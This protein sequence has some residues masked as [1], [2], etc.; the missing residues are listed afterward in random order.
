MG[1]QK[2]LKILY[3]SINWRYA[4]PTGRL[5]PMMLREVGETVLYGPGFV[6][7][8]ELKKGLR[9]FV[10]KAGPF[11]AAV[12]TELVAFS[13]KVT[14]VDSRQMRSIRRQYFFDF[15]TSHLDYV[16]EI[17][18][19]FR[20]LSCPRLISLLQS[21]LYNWTNYHIDRISETAQYYLSN[22]PENI[23]LVE[24]MKDRQREFWARAANDRFAHFV[25]ERASD[26][27][28]FPLFV[29]PE[30]FNNTPLELRPYKWAVPGIQ[31]YYR[32]IAVRELK[33]LKTTRSSNTT[34]RS[35]SA[36]SR[37]LGS[38]SPLPITLSNF[39]FRRQLETAQAVYTCG[40]VIRQPIRKFFE[41]PAAGALLVCEP[42][43]GCLDMGFSHGTNMMVCHPSEIRHVND[44]LAADPDK[45]QVIA[46]AGQQMVLRNHS[47]SARAKQLGACLEVI[48]DGSFDGAQ[49]EKGQFCIRKRT[50][51][52]CEHKR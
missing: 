47:L 37:I 12:T 14:N 11:D 9:C 41:V 49:W 5:V 21:D 48:A 16:S 2:R 20:E 35:I 46:S 8:E 34:A 27:I 26:V 1:T 19:D 30:E 6:S 3:V 24:E 23:I 52:N 4:N 32:N 13:E 51:S 7:N 15:P 45:A 43:A 17:G 10:D 50:V 18:K 38:A 44:L 28:S 29:G 39:F 33:R 40:S 22:G 42:C 31:Y 36:L 25:R